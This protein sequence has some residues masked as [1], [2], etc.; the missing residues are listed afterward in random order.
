MTELMAIARDKGLRTME[1]EVLK[2][3][4]NMLRLVTSLGFSVTTSAHDPGVKRV[5]RVL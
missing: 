5:V 1:G 4:A 2:N 3:N